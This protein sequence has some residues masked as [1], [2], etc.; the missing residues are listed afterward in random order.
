MDKAVTKGSEAKMIFDRQSLLDDAIGQYCPWHTDLGKGCY[1]TRYLF[2]V[3]DEKPGTAT[4]LEAYWIKHH[5]ASSFKCVD[6]AGNILSIEFQYIGTTKVIA[7]FKCNN[8]T[9]W[10]VSEENDLQNSEMIV[11]M[12]APAHPENDVNIT[13]KS[14]DSIVRVGIDTINVRIGIG[15]QVFQSD[16]VFGQKSIPD[17]LKLVNEYLVNH[18]SHQTI[19]I[20]SWHP[21]LIRLGF[22]DAWEALNPI[23]ETKNE[24]AAWCAVA[25]GLSDNFGWVATGAVGVLNA[26]L[27]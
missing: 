8:V 9:E 12:S 24:E 19:I 25:A 6:S 17:V 20:K 18:L 11:T 14:Y 3:P 26:Y 23:R 2:K 5:R 13:I 21:D 16:L 10:I 15:H 1:P 4:A 27:L 22:I 7:T